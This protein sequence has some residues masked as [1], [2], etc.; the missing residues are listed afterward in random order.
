MKI[1]HQIKVLISINRSIFMMS[2]LKTSPKNLSKKK[3]TNKQTNKKWVPSTKYV[4]KAKDH[5]SKGGN[6][7]LVSLSCSTSLT[8]LKCVFH[9]CTCA[10]LPHGAESCASAACVEVVLPH[11]SSSE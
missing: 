3:Q 5:L 4:S 9:K 1:F 11:Q 7:V 10:M 8:W 2:N 6:L